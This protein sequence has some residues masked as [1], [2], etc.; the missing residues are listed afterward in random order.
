VHTHYVGARGNADLELSLKLACHHR[1]GLGMRFAVH[2]RMY[3]MDQ[4][5]LYLQVYHREAQS[6]LSYKSVT[7]I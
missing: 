7:T 2:N 1:K 3:T 6:H 4:C 5:F